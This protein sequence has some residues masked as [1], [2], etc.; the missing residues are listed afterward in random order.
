MAMDRIWRWALLSLALPAAFWPRWAAAEPYLALRQ[1]LACSVCHVNPTGGG[2]R[3]AY[4]VAFAQRVLPAHGLSAG[5][6]EWTG[7]F[8]DFLRLGGD[9]RESWSRT[10]VPHQPAQQAWALD[11]L[12]LYA[13]LAM[14]PH[15]LAISVDESLAPGNAHAQEAYL[16]YTDPDASWYAKAG[17]FYLPFGWRL[18]DN[19]AFVREVSGIGMTTPDQGIELGF[20]RPGWS[21]QIAFTNG[22]ANAGTGSGHQWTGQAVALVPPGR[23]GVAMA[24]TQAAAGNRRVAGVFGG[25]VTG[26]L[27][28]LGE[29]D[30]VQ[31]DGFPEGRRKLLASLAE[32]DW[33]I[34]R[35]HNLKLS[36]EFYDPD[37]QV[38]QDQQAR[39]SLVYEFTPLPFVQIRAGLRRYDGIPQNDLQN[40]KLMFIEIHGFL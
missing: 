17:Q 13:D 34:A 23:I 38:A 3:S 35:G 2:L 7:G 39:A 8:G 21:A 20:E 22:A 25:L 10:E 37:R 15:R 29:V 32:V 16:R 27:V 5:V 40:R 31:D 11:Q 36:Y 30:A 4:G 14:I 1:G 9:L 19:T 28:W 18:Q 26:P 12:R 24:G 6:P 33:G